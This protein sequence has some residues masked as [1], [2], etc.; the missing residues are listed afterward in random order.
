MVKK[1]SYLNIAFAIAYFLL[2]L[3]NSTSFAMIGIMVVIVFN[4]VVLK[5]LKKDEP[6][7]S[8]HFV[9]GATNIFFAG[10][11]ILWVSH[12]VISSLNYHYF[13]N[14]WFYITFTSLFIISILTHFILVLRIGRTI[15]Q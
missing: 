15:N 7:K 12:I 10:F 11:M 3:L 6:F 13:G 2:Y 8:V 14:T 1:L 5:H 9:M 4:A